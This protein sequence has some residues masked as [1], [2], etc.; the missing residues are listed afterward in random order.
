MAHRQAQALA[1]H[2]GEGI[3]HDLPR[4]RGAAAGMTDNPW[5][6]YLDACDGKKPI[7]NLNEPQAGFYRKPRKER[8]GGR[9]TFVPVAYYPKDGGLKCRIGDR[10]ASADEALELWNGGIHEHWVLE[11]PW[12]AVAQEDGL[13]P[14]EHPL[15]PLQRH[16]QPPED[17]SFEGL[18][19]AVEDLAREANARVE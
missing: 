11:K 12:R 6:W 15:V 4:G 7:A 9:I 5:Q 19:A 2:D 14:D 18:H 13:W 8:Y 17:D 16:N 10:E 1:R 3:R